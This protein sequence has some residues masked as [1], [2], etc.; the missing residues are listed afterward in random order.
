MPVVIPGTTPNPNIAN[1]PNGAP[2]TTQTNLAGMIGEVL[3]WNPDAPPLLITRWINNH[4]RSII[5]SRRWYG[6]LVR[7]QIV[8]PAMVRGG[9]ATG[10]TGSPIINGNGTS[11]DAS[12]IGQQFRFGYQGL[13]RT[14]LNV[15]TINQALTLDTQ[16]A[17]PSVTAV[18]YQIATIWVTMGCNIRDILH[19]KNQQQ[20][21]PL[22]INVPQQTLDMRDTWR[23]EIGWVTCLGAK[24][25]TIDG[26]LQ[27]ELYPAPLNQQAIP[28]FGYIQPNDLQTD[29]DTPVVFLRTDIL[30]ALA[31]AD[32][33]TWRGPKRN[34][35]YD[36]TTAK[37]KRDYAEAEIEKMKNFDDSR[38]PQDS[39]WDYG[40]EGAYGGQGATWAQNHAVSVWDDYF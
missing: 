40:F 21:W 2:C 7:G 25:P 23:T 32:G 17:G 37:L 8:V 33:L 28:F 3:L 27:V 30:V 15:D 4:Y 1:Q 11:W 35:Y 16:F 6:C 22:E 38:W 10:S 12:L 18:G 24:E 29:N 26:Q 39:S 31:I 20:G 19:A 14:I 5:E 13:W 9:T 34:P 36:Q